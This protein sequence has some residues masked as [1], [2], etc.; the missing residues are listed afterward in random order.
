MEIVKS[1]HNFNS[2]HNENIININIIF[3][4]FFF[5]FL[6]ISLLFYKYNLHENM[7][8]DMKNKIELQKKEINNENTKNNII[9]E[10]LNNEIK[11]INIIEK[12]EN[13]NF[14]LLNEKINN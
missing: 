7:L 3:V 9:E 8:N 13:E 6:I 14:I 12:K 4:L 1:T 11:K 5:Q 2:I 10:K